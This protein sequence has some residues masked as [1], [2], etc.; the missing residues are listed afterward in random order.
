MDDGKYFYDDRITPVPEKG[1][2]DPEV[3]AAR[4]SERVIRLDRRSFIE[5]VGCA[6]ALVAGWG[7]PALALAEGKRSDPGCHGFH[8]HTGEI[9][10]IAFSPDGK[11]M[12]SAGKDSFIKIWSIPEGDLTRGIKDGIHAI[13]TIT[14]SPDGKRLV[15]GGS[16][17]T[18]KLWSVDSGNLENAPMKHGSEVKTVCFDREGETIISGGTDNTVLFWSVPDTAIKQKISPAAQGLTGTAFHSGLGLVA[19][20]SK[21]GSIWVHFPFSKNRPV[22]FES[23]QGKV[24]CVSISPDGRIIA[25]GGYDGTIRLWNAQTGGR[26]N[27]LTGH[28]ESVYAVGFSP[29]GKTL[30]SGGWDCMIRLWDVASGDLEF[31]LEKPLPEKITACGFSPDGNCVA[32]GLKNGSLLVWFY[33][34]MTVGRCLMDETVT[35][36]KTAASEYRIEGENEA[37]SYRLEGRTYTRPCGSPIPAGAT[38]VC[39]CVAGFFAGTGSVCICNTVTV[40][41]GTRIPAGSVC[42]CN[43]IMVGGMKLGTKTGLKTAPAAPK[44]YV[45]STTRSTNRFCSCDQVCTCNLIYY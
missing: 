41:V 14:F 38:C 17:D 35:K 20:G 11:L 45:P 2:K 22:Q 3:Y 32:A 4:I 44:T 5:L 31:V 26:I 16:D 7:I 15:S 43:T 34:G 42:T 37:V 27:I 10:S 40:P 33:P 21:N 25:S 9:R 30:V 29:D 13:N 36:E 28:E 8:A 24:H 19:C 1:E 18:V 23:H 39:N 12:A 6:G